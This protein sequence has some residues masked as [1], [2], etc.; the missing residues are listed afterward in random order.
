MVLKAGLALIPM[1]ETG[2]SKDESLCK[3]VFRG[4]SKNPANQKMRQKRTRPGCRGNANGYTL[5]EIMAVITLIG[6]MAAIVFPVYTLREEKTGVKYIGN[7][8]ESDIKSIQ[9]EALCTQSELTIIF[10]RQGY[11]FKLGETSIVRSFSQYRFGFKLP[12]L[13]EEESESDSG[14][15]SDK[16]ESSTDA[17]P[18]L[19]VPMLKFNKEGFSTGL[20]LN[21]ESSHFSGSMAVDQDGV[22]KWNYVQKK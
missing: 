5:L 8:L 13:E 10:S 19:T 16:K 18:K 6:L 21:W 2:N 3:L 14:V 20:T 4:T 11:Q 17:D 12:E 15:T 1:L 9:E 7:L 22:L